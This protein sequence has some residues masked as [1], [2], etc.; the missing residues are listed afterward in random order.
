M[1]NYIKHFEEKL[2]KLDTY[3]QINYTKENTLTIAKYLVQNIIS[4]FEENITPNA[5]IQDITAKTSVMLPIAAHTVIR[6]AV[7]AVLAGKGF[8]AHAWMSPIEYNTHIITETI[9]ISLVYKKKNNIKPL[10]EY[11]YDAPTP[12]AN[13]FRKKIMKDKKAALIRALVRNAFPSKEK[14]KRQ[15]EANKKSL[16]HILYMSG[17]KDITLSMILDIRNIPDWREYTDDIMKAIYSKLNGIDIHILCV[18]E[19]DGE[20]LIMYSLK[21]DE[22]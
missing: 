16:T 5:S 17:I 8:F 6:D 14:I 3:N 21:I 22:E 13:N 10:S 15:I 20:L 4:S 18:R 2:M 19:V 11:T 9:E 12:E 1:N 7:V